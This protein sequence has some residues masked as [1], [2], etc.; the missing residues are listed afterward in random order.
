VSLPELVPGAIVAGR[1][2]VQSVL[3]IRPHVSTYHAITAPNQ[4]VALKVFDPSTTGRFDVVHA[5]RE[6]MGLLE[7]LPPGA[8]LA[9]VDAGRDAALQAPYCA[10]ALSDLPNLGQLVQL[11][12]LAAQE[13]AR[14]LLNLADVLEAAHRLGAVHLALKPTNVFVGPAPNWSVRIADFNVFSWYAV[15]STGLE[16]GWLAPEQTL[17]SVGALGPAADQFSAALLAFLCVTGRPYW[18]ALR[19]PS[20]DWG[21]LQQE[22][23]GPREAVSVVAREL[24]VEIDPA[25]DA[26]FARALSPRPEDRWPSTTEFARRVAHA[27]GLPQPAWE[28]SPAPSPPA[29]STS[30]ALGP[31]AA[32]APHAV[33]SHAERPVIRDEDTVSPASGPAARASARTLRLGRIAVGAVAFTALLLGATGIWAVSRLRQKNGGQVSATVS[34]PAARS[35]EVPAAAA[36]EQAAGAQAPAAS[37]SPSAGKE[38]AAH[39]PAAKGVPADKAEL[40]VACR[41]ECDAVL[42]AGK[43]VENPLEPQPLS[44]GKYIV[45]GL[46]SRHTSRTKVLVL[47]AGRRET[48]ELVLQP[49]GKFLKKCR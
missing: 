24:G 15:P 32:I 38:P 9:V 37:A 41:P 49:C 16:P 20:I 45:T 5:L 7:R 31:A 22:V 8:V 29:A 14:V 10:T 36:P 48:V 30:S 39:A 35:T 40:V 27:V 19:S 46:K 18:R 28:P 43:R 12:P 47:E 26:V 2:T 17:P 33:A 11:C 6:C 21:S 3:L 1:F 13:M 23:R 34:A 25:L 4:H 42:V 44:P